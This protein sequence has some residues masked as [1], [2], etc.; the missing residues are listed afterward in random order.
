MAA[1]LSD[2]KNNKGSRDEYGE[3]HDEL[4]WPSLSL[5]PKKE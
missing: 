5:Q 3:E 4:R 1:N 2:S